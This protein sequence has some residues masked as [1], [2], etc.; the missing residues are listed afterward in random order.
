MR[1]AQPSTKL[2]LEGTVNV[3]S[4][5]KLIVQSATGS[6][7]MLPQSSILTIPCKRISSIHPGYLRGKSNSPNSG[8]APRTNGLGLRAI[9]QR[10][11]VLSYEEDD[12][13]IH[14]VR[15]KAGAKVMGCFPLTVSNRPVGALY[16]YLQDE[17]QFNQLELLML[18]NFVNQAAMAIYHAHN[19]VM[20]RH[21]LDRKEEEL[22]RLRRAGLLISSRLRLE[23]TLEAILQMALGSNRCSLWHFSFIG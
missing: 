22:T 10:R 20:M 19:L 2:V 17:R 15:A 8:D 21:N 18:D 4:T 16:V 13:E 7:R 5:L 6:C 12:M 1:L 9:R 11:R 23:E 14:P 3:E